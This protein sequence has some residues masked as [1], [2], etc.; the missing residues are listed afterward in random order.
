MESLNVDLHVDE[1]N[2]N[3]YTI[4]RNCF[5]HS[6]AD[7]IVKEFDNWC[8]EPNNL[9]NINQK[10]RVCNFHTYSE[11]TLDLVINEDVNKI[12]SSFFNKQQ[13]VY[14]SLT[15]RE[16]TEQDFH[17]DTP[18]FYTNPIN[19]YCGVWYALED[20]HKDAGPLK[21]YKK[22]ILLGI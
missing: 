10:N 17:I 20:I 5:S 15:F 13:V 1:I 14:T 3:G 12:V 7:I 4:I 6:L 19:Q 21:Y 9:F 18:H 16:G 11:N 8:K 22:V 2:N